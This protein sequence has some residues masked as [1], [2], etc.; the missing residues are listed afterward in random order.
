MLSSIEAAGVLGV[1]RV[2]V[3]TV[4]VT[5]SAPP[6]VLEVRK[7]ERTVVY[8]MSMLY[9]NVANGNSSFI[10]DISGTPYSVFLGRTVDFNYRLDGS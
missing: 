5:V 3:T 4:C 10:G 8:D 2:N 1:V 9:C 6:A 7:S